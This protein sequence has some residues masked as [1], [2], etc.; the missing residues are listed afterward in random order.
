[1]EQHD[2]AVGGEVAVGF[3]VVGPGRVGLGDRGERVL[4]DA[5]GGGIRVTSPRWAST[6]GVERD[7]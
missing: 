3:D 7:R 4:D 5:L 1:M 2:L 6:R